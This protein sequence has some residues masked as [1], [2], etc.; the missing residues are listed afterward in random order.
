MQMCTEERV[1]LTKMT[2][3]NLA[4]VFAPNLLRCPS[5]V[6]VSTAGYL[7]SR[8]VGFAPI[9]SAGACFGQTALHSHV[10]CATLFAPVG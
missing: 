5:Q 10:C 7:S 2:D 4:M 3:D 6:P 8:L 9:A 1:A